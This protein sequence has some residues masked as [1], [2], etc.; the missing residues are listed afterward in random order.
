M[1]QHSV[2]PMGKM[3]KICEPSA[4][5]G[6]PQNGSDP[7]LS[8]NNTDLFV[9]TTLEHFEEPKSMRLPKEITIIRGQ[10]VIRFRKLD[11]KYLTW[12]HKMFGSAEQQSEKGTLDDSDMA[13]LCERYFGICEWVTDRI[14][15]DKMKE[16]MSKTDISAF[17]P[18]QS[19]GRGL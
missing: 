11:P 5:E 13:T 7:Q 17:Q 14:G 18:P 12:I 15:D 6:A 2:S 9:A 1:N 3:F 8:Q 16:L 10:N 4:A 19:A